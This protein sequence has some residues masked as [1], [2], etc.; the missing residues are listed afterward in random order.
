MSRGTSAQLVG[1]AVIAAFFVAVFASLLHFANLDPDHGGVG[2]ALW[3]SATRMLRSPPPAWSPSD[4]GYM[5]V[6]LLIIV[7]GM[8]LVSILVGIFTS[9][10]RSL[11]LRMSAGRSP[12]PV[13]DHTLILGWSATLIGIVAELVRANKHVRRRSH[14]VILADRDKMAMDEELRTGIRSTGKTRLVTRR[15]DPF[16]H[17]DLELVNI[18]MARAIIVVPPNRATGPDRRA[19]DVS[20]DMEVVKTLMAVVNSPRREKHPY[21]I[22]TAIQ[23]ETNVEV[24]QLAAAGEVSLIPSIDVISRIT[25]QTCRQSGLPMVYTE[26]MSFRGSELYFTAEKRLVGRTYREAVYAYRTSCVIGLL[27]AE[28]NAVLNPPP[29]R[30]IAAGE[31]LIVLSRNDATIHFEPVSPDRAPVETEAITGHAA[32]A[33]APEHTL[34]L[35]WNSGGSTIVRQLDGYVAQGSTVQ[36]VVNTRA[37]A[38]QVEALGKTLEFQT[39]TCTVADPTQAPAFADL[40]IA[41]FDHIILLSYDELEAMKSDSKVLVTLLRVRNAQE[42]AGHHAGIV[43][44]MVLEKNAQVAQSNRDD[45]FVVGDHLVGLLYSQISENHELSQVFRALLTEEGSEIY[46]KPVEAYVRTGKPVSF[47]TVVEAALR[48]SETAIGYRRVADKRNAAKN[49]G[50]VLNPDKSDPVT[51]AEGDRIIVLSEHYAS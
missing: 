6:M 44:E 49:H 16:Q 29:D 20:A 3:T 2:A 33:M 24:A 18:D 27:D 14:I 45:E 30:E 8:L 37:Q 32:Q 23:D 19:T 28:R 43:S 10:F 4:P 51:F 21:R 34:V 31:E 25:A 5:I 13:T 1:L 9:G 22:V 12:V 46:L 11:M 17:R 47:Y 50:V 7:V 26:I 35:G 39:L 15:G 40:D 36:V 48:K 42:K 38:E 41:R